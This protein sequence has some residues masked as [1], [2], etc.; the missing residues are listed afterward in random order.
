M[1]EIIKYRKADIWQKVLAIFQV[2][3]VIT[4]IQGEPKQESIS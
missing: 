2:I 1:N 4:W 3:L